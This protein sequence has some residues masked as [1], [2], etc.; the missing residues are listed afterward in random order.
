MGGAGRD[1]NVRCLTFFVSQ[2]TASDELAHMRNTVKLV[3]N[4]FSIIL[5]KSASD[6]LRQMLTASDELAQMRNAHLACMENR[7]LRI[8]VKALANS[9]WLTTTFPKS[10]RNLHRINFVRCAY[11]S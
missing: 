7:H 3:D 4:D 10:L 11:R 2:L 8:L 1:K 5:E 9:H 6:Q